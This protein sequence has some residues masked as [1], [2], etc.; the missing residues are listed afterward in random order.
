MN[1]EKGN[2][3]EGFGMTARY[4]TKTEVR[5]PWKERLEY[6]VTLT[7][8]GRVI[9]ETPFSMGIAHIPGY[10][11][12]QRRVIEN[13]E[14]LIHALE[15]GTVPKYSPAGYM[16][17]SEPILPTLESVVSCLVL[18]SSAIDYADY[19]EWAQEFGYDP[20][21]REGERIYR[22]C[23]ETGLRLRSRIGES[24]LRKLQEWA[25]NQ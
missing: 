16:R 18:D 15:T 24:R 2:P 23:L 1:E 3:L 22:A 13:Q 14:F 25:A 8:R 21:S 7:Y 9:L 4:L 10:E 17:N 12:R 20:D 6:R 19:E 11:R 5:D